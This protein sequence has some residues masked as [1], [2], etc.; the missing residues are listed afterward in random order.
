VRCTI[1][2]M[3]EMYRRNALTQGWHNKLVQLSPHSPQ[4]LVLLH[5]SHLRK[6]GAPGIQE[7][8]SSETL[9]Q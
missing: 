3:Y 5:L 1:S 8:Q 7:K 6:V 4:T 9:L 2:V